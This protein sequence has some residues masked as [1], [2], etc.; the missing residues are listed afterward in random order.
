M[1][2]ESMGSFLASKTVAAKLQIVQGLVAKF[3]QSG[4]RILRQHQVSGKV[5]ILK[6]PHPVKP[7]KLILYANHQSQPCCGGSG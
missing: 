1:I 5:S 3:E 6:L 4:G 2:A 7:L